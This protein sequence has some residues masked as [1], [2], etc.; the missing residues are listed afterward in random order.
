[1]DIKAWTYEEYPAFSAPVPGAV[2]GGP[3]FFSDEM[4]DRFDAFAKRCLAAIH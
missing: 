1:M 4:L 3:E 2:R